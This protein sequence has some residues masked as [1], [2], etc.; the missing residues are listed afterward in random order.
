MTVLTIIDFMRIQDFVFASNRLVDIVTGSFLVETA[1]DKLVKDSLDSKGEIIVAA[2]GNVLLRFDDMDS[3]KAFVTRYTRRLYDEVPGLAVAAAHEEMNNGFISTY[4]RLLAKIQ[5]TKDTPRGPVF[6]GGFSVNE[7][8]RET[9]FPAVHY[10]EERPISR[11]ILRR[12]DKRIREASNERWKSM[13]KTTEISAT[14]E[15]SRKLDFP[16]DLD[17]LSRSKGDTSLIGIVHIDG[18][19]MGEQLRDVR[20][21]WQNDK[22]TDE[23]IIQ[24]MKK[25][26]D[27]I[28]RLGKSAF[29]AC[30]NT[31]TKSIEYK[32]DYCIRGAAKAQEISL[33]EDEN[34]EILYLPIRPVLLGGDDMTFICDARVAFSASEV[35][36]REFEHNPVKDLGIITACAGISFVRSHSPVSR[37]YDRAEDVCR[38]AK[39]WRH[40]K[41]T[42]VGSVIDWHIERGGVLD[43]VRQIRDEHLVVFSS[44]GEMLKLTLRPYPLEP[45]TSIQTGEWNWLTRVLLLDSKYGLIGGMWKKH[46]SKIHHLQEAA[47]QGP[48]EVRMLMDTWQ[49]T[50]PGL[51]LVDGLDD[52]YIGNK[53]PLVDAA[54]MLEIYYPLGGVDNA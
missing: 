19:D 34:R 11:M 6:P 26:S 41:G 49:A 32:G 35:I 47:C 39:R 25:I 18:N 52:G 40:E 23:Q 3:A 7:S 46:R 1:A 10:D 16:M 29:T 30:L 48:E 2:G 50:S 51:H 13:L 8:C 14:S 38:L 4:N 45:D 12:R 27:D 42:D 28:N 31:I 44:R 33:R 37:A 21:R 43:P 5:E 54:E 17:Y 9:G 22:L 53:T 20:E 15:S 24:N 36:L